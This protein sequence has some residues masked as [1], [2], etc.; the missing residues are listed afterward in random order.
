MNV[1]L[2]MV[3]VNKYV[4]IKYHCSIVLVS[5]AST[6]LMINSVQV[7]LYIHTQYLH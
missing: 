7:L 6:W 4:L 5:L 3:A 2:T 1:I